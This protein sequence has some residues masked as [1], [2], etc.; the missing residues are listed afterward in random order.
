[1]THTDYEIENGE[2]LG[3]EPF[4]K[5]KTEEFKPKRMIES[6]QKK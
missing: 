3:W 4:Y 6:Y 5:L 2:F 1:M